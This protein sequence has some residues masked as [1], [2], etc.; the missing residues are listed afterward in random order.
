[1]RR[2]LFA[3]SLAALLAALAGCQTTPS[4]ESGAP[5]DDKSAAT[6]GAGTGAA[7]SGASGDRVTG[8][9]TG[10]GS[11]SGVPAMLKDPN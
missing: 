1:M 11:G 10:S 9:T 6:A 8:V 5:I 3:A 4:T 2:F 7:T